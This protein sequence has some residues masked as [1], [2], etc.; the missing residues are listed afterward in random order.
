MES[1]GPIRDQVQQATVQLEQQRERT[2]A[3]LD[4]AAELSN[5]LQETLHAV[6]SDLREL[7]LKARLAPTVPKKRRCQRCRWC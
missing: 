1:L 5:K 2:R 3:G 4:V 7:I 6:G